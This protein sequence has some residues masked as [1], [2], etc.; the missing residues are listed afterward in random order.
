ME[1]VFEKYYPELV[2]A[3]AAAADKEKEMKTK[4]NC[5]SCTSVWDARNSNIWENGVWMK[6]LVTAVIWPDT[7]IK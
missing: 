3:Q 4:Y 5:Y 1:I 6:Y 7:I 2:D